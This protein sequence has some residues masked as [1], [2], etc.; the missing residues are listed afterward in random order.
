[1]YDKIQVRQ[2][3]TLENYYDLLTEFQAEP[4]YTNFGIIARTVCHNNPVENTGSYKLYYYSNSSLFHCFS[5]CEE[6]SFD[7]FQL[8]IKVADLQHGLSYDLNDAVR[9][10]AQF[11]GIQSSYYNPEEKESADWEYIKELGR[12]QEIETTDYHAQLKEYDSKILERFN[13]TAAITP[14]LREGIG[15]NVLTS[16]RIGYFPGDAQITIPHYDCANRLVGVRGRALCAQDAE[17]YGKYRPIRIGRTFLTHPLGFNLYNLNHSQK[18]IAVMRK[19]LLFESEKSALLYRTYFGDE[20]DISVAC[21]GSNLSPYQVQLL[22]DAGA[23]E[24]IIALDRQFQEL[25]DDEFRHLTR[26]LIKMND[27]YKNSI[28]LSF[29]FDKNKITSYKASPIDEGPDKF[30]QLYKERIYL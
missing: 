16:A 1:M 19:A 27:K 14:W 6:P 15:Q 7:I 2:A 3:L 8:V 28:R 5:G 13:Y 30:L 17:L 24:I 12:I 11:C 22:I 10:V 9:Y 26:N 20:N 21:C 25:N 4:I 29:I 23:N 18:A